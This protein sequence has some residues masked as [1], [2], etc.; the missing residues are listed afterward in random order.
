MLMDIIIS[1]E[2]Q[3]Y[4]RLKDIKKTYFTYITNA[5]KYVILKTT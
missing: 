1:T 3:A 5:V 4:E 2:T